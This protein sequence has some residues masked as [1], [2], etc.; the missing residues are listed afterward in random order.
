MIDSREAFTRLAMDV[1]SMSGAASIMAPYLSGKGAMLMLHRV[2]DHCQ[3]PLGLNSHLSITP[4]FLDATIRG[5]KS[6]GYRF[7]GMDEALDRLKSRSRERFATITADDGYRDNLTEALPVIEQLDA[8]ITIYVA[9]NL[10]NGSVDLWW[11][12][13]EQT[14]LAA[15]TIVLPTAQGTVSIDTSSRPRKIAAAKQV[16]SYLTGDIAERDR[17]TVVRDLAALS[18]VDP[19]NPC[20]CGLMDWDEI[21][22]IAAH[23][24]VTIGAHTLN[25]YFLARL[26]D[27][28]AGR[29]MERA[30]RILQLELGRRPRHLAY[31][32]GSALAVGKREV[33][34]A[35]E[36]GYASAVTTRHGMLHGEHAAHL[37]ALPRISVN[38]RFQKMRHVR[39]MLSGVTAPLANAGRRV[40]T[41]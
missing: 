12:V 14:V 18:G 15:S 31:P 37:H 33:Q 20:R 25:H 39:T 10:T 8:P 13:L 28:D 30:D 2:S 34:L 7:V 35:R 21:R 24:L 23:P 17:R 4:A 29:E 38:G 41:T 32:Y 26:S 16:A 1:L 3:S 9:P 6:L 36:V 5:M 11:E 22:Q 27:A 40:V 19:A